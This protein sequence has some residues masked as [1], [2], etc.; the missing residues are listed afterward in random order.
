M[1]IHIGF[2]RTGTTWLQEIF[3]KQYPKFEIV[4]SHEEVYLKIVHP[5]CLDFSIDE[6]CDFFHNRIQTC[7]NSGKTPVI[8]SEILCGSP[9]NGGRESKIIADRIGKIFPMAKILIVIREQISMITSTYKQYV[10]GGGV[11]NLN[12]FISPPSLSFSYNWFNPEHFKFHRL[13]KYYISIFGKSNVK[14]MFFEEFVKDKTL[15]C[16]NILRYLDLSEMD[17]ELFNSRKS[18]KKFNQSLSDI[19]VYLKR[20]LN[21]LVR[22]KTN[23][24]P[25]VNIP[26]IQNFGLGSLIFLD[27]FVLNRLNFKKTEKKLRSKYEDFFSDSNRELSEIINRDLSELG[28]Y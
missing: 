15:F 20:Y 14:I 2:H 9:F 8:S 6:A 7:C 13:I 4:A 16:N 26:F 25:I 12:Q 21:R 1:L 24:Y 18:Q 28:Y 27:R 17:T 11:G 22:T 3:F 5:N 10:L 19:S 23:P